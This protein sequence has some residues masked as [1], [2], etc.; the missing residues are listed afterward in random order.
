M[1]P[2]P[3][4]SFYQTPCCL[5]GVR[6]SQTGACFPSDPAQE[7]AWDGAGEE[8]QSPC[9][10]GQGRAPHPWPQHPWK[11]WSLGEPTLD[12]A[13]GGVWIWVWVCTVTWCSKALQVPRQWHPCACLGPSC[14]PLSL[15]NALAT[16][17][18]EW[19]GDWKQ[20]ETMTLNIRLGQTPRTFAFLPRLNYSSL[21]TL[22]P[23]P[24]MVSF[25]HS[26]LW[27]SPAFSTSLP[28]RG[29]PRDLFFLSEFFTLDICISRVALIHIQH[30]DIVHC[31]THLWSVLCVCFPSISQTL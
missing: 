22:N 27:F 12:K 19:R 18:N 28:Y 30:C 8:R 29:A 6:S 10:W 17:W 5:D 20:V 21:S 3:T 1:F 2:V 9:G 14:M 26:R 23:L 24:G 4:V 13:R 31:L 11:T 25:L 16:G 15:P 7:P